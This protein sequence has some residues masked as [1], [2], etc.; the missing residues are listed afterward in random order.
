MQRRDFITLLGSAAVWPISA[1]AQQLSRKIPRVGWLAPGSEAVQENLEQ[2]RLGMRELGY[3]E[4][5][6]VETKYLYAD[7]NFDRLGNL[8]G[9]LVA[10]NVDIIVTAGTPGCLAA[11]RATTTIPIVFAVSSDP[12]GTGVVASLSRPGG[13]ITGLS[14]MATD[15]SAKR[16]EL[17]QILIPSIREVAVMWDRSNPGMA[18]RVQETRLAAEQLKVGFYDSGARS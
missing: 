10:D 18:L 9:V 5:R 7:G 15:L 17:L 2:Y 6:T 13:N 16:M 8:A 11:K 14:L 12:L 3:V 4:G 1:R